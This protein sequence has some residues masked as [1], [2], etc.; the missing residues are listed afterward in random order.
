MEHKQVTPLKW[1]DGW[2]RTRI[3]DRK[4][5]AQWKKPKGFY[6]DALWKELER[7]GGTAALMT[8]NDDPRDPGVAV[9]FSRKKDDFSWQDGLG[10]QGV[11][12]TLEQIDSAYRQL[13]RKYHP[14]VEGGDKAMFVK[15]AEYRDQAKR[16]V[17]GTDRLDHEHV[18]A[19]DMFNE[20]RL[21]IA[22]LKMTLTA[23]RTIERCG[24][25]SVLDRVMEKSFARQMITEVSSGSVASK[26]AAAAR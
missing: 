22:A 15:I 25:S 17:L 13:S 11:V 18:I 16:W 3:Q 4:P 23:L 7:L 9:Y 26:P 19:C 12:P 5:Q 20:V 2:M 10:L 1:P 21:N 8:T 14:D 24:A 6:L